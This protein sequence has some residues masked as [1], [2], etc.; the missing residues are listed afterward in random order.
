MGTAPR[1]RAAQFLRAV[2]PLPG[3]RLDSRARAILSERERQLFD[4]MPAFDRRHSL[5]VW[6]RIE[7]LA[8]HDGDLQAAALLHDVGK[9]MPSVA[10]RVALVLALRFWPRNLTRWSR[11][12]PRSFRGALWGLAGHA[13]VGGR[14]LEAAGSSPRAVEIVRR[15]GDA[16]MPEAAL[17]GY[18]DSQ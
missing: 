16:E 2:A 8:P 3:P 13:E 7:E 9:G 4:R 10:H 14:F 18:V 1:H 12:P 11:M 15:Q 17:L 6:R 5:A